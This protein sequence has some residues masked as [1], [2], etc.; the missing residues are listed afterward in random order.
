MLTAE[1][2]KDLPHLDVAKR[3]ATS[4]SLEAGEETA[5]GIWRL[6]QRGL[7]Y[8]SPFAVFAT[9]WLKNGQMKRADLAQVLVDARKHVRANLSKTHTTVVAGVDFALW[10]RWCAAEGM[11]VP[12]GMRFA[13]PA[14]PEGNHSAVF[15]RSAG[16]LVDSHA[17]LW[18]HIKSDVAENAQSLFDWLR[19]RLNTF[20]DPEKTIYQ[21]ASA[22]SRAPDGTGGKVLGSRFSENLN[23]PADP[24]TVQEHA[25]VGFED[26]AHL[27]ASYVVTQRLRINWEQVLQLSPE[28]IEDLVGRTD[29]DV[30]IP[31]KDTRTHI[32]SARIQ[33]DSGNSRFIMR[34]GLPFGHS[35][36]VS[37]DELRARGANLRDEEGIYFAGYSKE[38]AML[39]RALASQVGRESGFMRDRLLSMMKGDVGGI[40]YVPSRA[41]L[42]LDLEE[43]LRLRNMD[44]SRFPGVNWHLVSRHFTATSPN[45][46]MHYSHQEYLYSMATMNAEDR[47]KYRPPSHRVLR[48]LSSTFARWQDTWYFSRQQ[49]ELA[50]LSAY[51]EQRFGAQEARR[52]MGLSVVER[53]GWSVRMA[54][55]HVFVSKEYGHR[56]RH[57]DAQGNWINGADTYSL[58]PME[59]IV[60][61]M[62]NIGIGQGRYMID[63]ARED[64]R[65]SQFFAGLSYASPVGH[66]VPHH[67]EVLRQGLKVMKEDVKRR[68]ETTPDVAKK[69]FYEGVWLALEGV[70]EHLRAYA[71]L[72]AETAQALPAGMTAERDN[73]RQ[74][75]SRLEWLADGKPRTF[76]EATQL[77]FTLHTCL[78][79]VGEVTA[80]GRIDQLLWSFYEADIRAGTLT[81]ELAQEVLDCFWIKVG[82]KAQ[83][84]RLYLEDH[85]P[86]GNLAM[87]G[88]SGNYPQGSSNNQWI[89]QVTVGG[90]VAD[91]SP[92]AGLPAYNE[93]TRL[94]LRCA[95]RLP[96]N[97]PCLS[98]RVRPDIPKDLLEEA[99]NALLSGG[100]HPILLQDEKIIPGLVASGQSVGGNVA[101]LANGRWDSHVELAH[102]RDYACDGCY[103]PQLAG[104]S[105]FTLGGFTTLQP[106]E[107]ALNRGKLWASAGPTWFRGQRT[108]FT[109]RAVEEIRSY[110]ELEALF[111]EHFRFMYAKQADGLVGIFGQMAAICP[112]PLLSVLTDGCLDKGLDI[113]GGGAR[114]NAVAPC[115]TGLSTLINS[116]WA[117][118]A[119]VFQPETAC[120][121]LPELVEALI[122]DWGYK[123]VEPFISPLMG[124]ARIEAQASRYKR[125]REVAMGLPRF[126]RGNAEVDA[127][128]DLILRKVAKIAV[129][130]FTQ[131]AAETSQKML[132]LATALGTPEQPFGGFQI[133]PGVGTFENYLDWGSM[134]GASADGRR[135]GEP[136]ASDLSPAPSFSDLPV[137]HQKAG[138]LSA[139]KGFSGEGVS[140][141]WDAAPVDFNLR[142]DFPR[143]ALVEALMAFAQGVGSNL[144]TITVASP[145]TFEGATR[146]P[147]K[148]DLLRARMGGWSEFFIAMFPAHQAEHQRRPLSTVD[149]K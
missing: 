30:I 93:L 99:S 136:I 112:S 86:F 8:T 61:Q 29:K 105:W 58:L 78:H 128:G 80:I 102:A 123:M 76:L 118:R 16:T 11:P 70:S 132:N 36:A 130:V 135:L 109:S 40:F 39:E 115:F 72:A 94:A 98:L 49:Q 6:M 141:F 26:E 37:N 63:Y 142:E 134:E 56:G 117:I 59:H 129:E 148:Y 91:D 97:A 88:M 114:Y 121:S 23:N 107:A 4:L 74:I 43:P 12:T 124:P 111:F 108:S 51:L 69:Q 147:E 45:G 96:L 54:I 137:E 1:L 89:Q 24:I 101:S 19:E 140:A 83:L 100:A 149:P 64:E 103:E 131:P 18:F 27:G 35:R 90:T 126:G 67:A 31:S 87:G 7:V 79:L 22:R 3:N 127:F 17:D 138:L 46:Y 113:Y 9:F 106:L 119:M 65:L 116:L 82:E 92:G 68:Q 120:T 5:H 48:L 53:M 81:P 60:G 13:F 52:I 44:W 42:K 47:E 32:K 144:I 2:L 145:S 122:C 21:F 110:E 10:K 25:V 20:C 15:E 41:D 84:N 71:R 133:Q 73:L 14:D 146:D 143:D 75:E 104:R 77:L 33:D 62:P 38:A 55:G 139:L 85:Q 28:G 95:A 34:L 125:L 57:Q 50:P 66:V